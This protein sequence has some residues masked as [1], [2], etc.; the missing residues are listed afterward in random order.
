MP[1]AA[2]RLWNTACS[3]L[4]S[5][6]VLGVKGVLVGL[7][8]L[9]AGRARGRGWGA[10]SPHCSQLP[11]TPSAESEHF[12]HAVSEGG[13]PLGRRCLEPPAQSVVFWH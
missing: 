10:E 8:T 9:W 7:G 6:A 11:P 12:G 3:V 4:G 1:A 5:P 2:Q 13:T